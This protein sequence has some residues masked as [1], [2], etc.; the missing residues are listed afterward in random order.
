MS[1]ALD[2]VK[3]RVRVGDA[4]SVDAGMGRWNC[5]GGEETQWRSV[6]C[7]LLQAS[8]YMYNTY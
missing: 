5:A 6:S 1:F 4:C 7:I 3:H 8:Y 2:Y